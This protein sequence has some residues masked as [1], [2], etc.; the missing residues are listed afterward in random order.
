MGEENVAYRHSGILGGCIKEGNL[1][2]FGS[3]NELR[4]H[5]SVWNK[6][7]VAWSHS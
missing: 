3:T 4:R 7:G 6:P 5:Y 2:I 1:V